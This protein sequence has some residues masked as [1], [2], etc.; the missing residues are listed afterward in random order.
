MN[1]LHYSLGFPPFRRGGMT[2]YCIDLIEQQLKDGHKVSMIWPGRIKKY[3]YKIKIKKKMNYKIDNL[4]FC[5]SYEIIN[6]LPISLLNGINNI[7][8]F[9]QKKD[10]LV[11]K[12]FLEEKKIEV[13]HIHTL[14]GL[15]KEWIQIAKKLNIKLVYTTHDYFG[16]C[17]KWGL[18]YKGKV[19]EDDLGCTKC[20]D[21]NKTALSL[22]KI[23]ILQS[24]FYKYIKEWKIIKALRK[25]HN[26]NL[27]EKLIDNYDENIFSDKEIFKYAEEYK[28]L[29]NY[30]IYILENMDLI[31]FNSYNTEKIFNKY[32]STQ[33]NGQ[34]V[35]ITHS[36]ISDNREVRKYNNKLNIGY[37]GPITEH[38]GFFLLKKVCDDIYSEGNK[39][40]RLHIFNQYHTK[41]DYIIEHKPYKYSELRKIM[42]YIDVLVV[43]SL[44]NETFGFTVLESL[45]YGVPVIIS[46]KVGAKDLIINNKSGIVFNGHFDELKNILLELL[47]KPNEKLREMNN[48][49]LNYVEI[50]NIK[51]HSNKINKIYK[52]L[53]EGEN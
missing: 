32:F 53:L 48:Y 22:K 45:S 23:K 14:M 12:Y 24:N 31:H 50:E 16:I 42:S 47:N 38:K 49:I 7:N 18:M 19:C 4:F 6:P 17:P 46:D 21:C 44:W 3:G 5:E 20:V 1:I 37:L 27:Y 13:I 43:P 11:F 39:S 34:V 9:T 10:E 41:E 8:A 51:N 36:S 40:F 33:K 35:S 2:K 52:E 25:Q 15:P 28:N 26:T 30:Y 29:R